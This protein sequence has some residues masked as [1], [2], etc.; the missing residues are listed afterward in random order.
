MTKYEE[1]ALGQILHSWPD[2]LTFDEII[3]LCND[4]EARNKFNEEMQGLDK[5]DQQLII[6]E[7]YEAY[8]WEHI[9]KKLIELKEATEITFKD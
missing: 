1:F 2:F 3:A 9:A 8:W 6:C 5:D 7:E 4:D